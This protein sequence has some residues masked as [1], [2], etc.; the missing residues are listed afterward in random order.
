MFAK[1]NTWSSQLRK[2]TLELSLL[3]LLSKGEQ[4]GY[5]LIHQLS[6]IAGPKFKKGTVYPLLSRLQK[7][8]LINFKWKESTSGPPRKYFF[9]TDNGASVLK[10]M[11]KIWQE[12][13]I[14]ID[15]TIV[16]RM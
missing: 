1:L 15:S 14:S 5:D 13:K 6:G 12:F 10:D 2:G 11:I 4:Y 9:L 8:N 3:A 7:E 16:N